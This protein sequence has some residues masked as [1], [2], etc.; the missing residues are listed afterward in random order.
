L[1]FS[2]FRLTTFYLAY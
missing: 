1:A 2:A